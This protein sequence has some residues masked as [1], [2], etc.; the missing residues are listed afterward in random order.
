MD[1]YHGHDK[2]WEVELRSGMVTYRWGRKN[3]AGQSKAESASDKVLLTAERALQKKLKEGYRHV[4][5]AG[6]ASVGQQLQPNPDPN[7]SPN[8]NPILEP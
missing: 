5:A 7:S 6:D 3:T 8:P 2:Y 1:T 4:S